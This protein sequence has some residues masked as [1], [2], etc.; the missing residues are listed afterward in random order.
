[1][2]PDTAHY[3]PV[4][5]VQSKTNI[6]VYRSVQ[7]NKVLLGI[8]RCAVCQ[9]IHKSRRV[10]TIGYIIAGVIVFS[11]LGY[12]LADTGG[13]IAGFMISAF[14]GLMGLN[15]LENRLVE[16]QGILTLEDGARNNMVV[17]NFLAGGWSL[18]PP[19][20]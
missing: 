9:K 1:M 18:T 3:A 17:K 12:W 6:V 20:A 14:A 11:G 5:K 16:G 7:Y 10:V 4:Y 8:P 19:V 13:A 2:G 15:P